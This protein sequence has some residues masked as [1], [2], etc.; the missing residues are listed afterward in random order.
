MEILTIAQGSTPPPFLPQSC[1]VR[2]DRHRRLDV[3]GGSQV[4]PGWNL[5]PILVCCSFL[6]CDSPNL[7]ASKARSGESSLDASVFHGPPQKNQPLALPTDIWTIS[8]FCPTC[9]SRTKLAQQPPDWPIFSATLFPQAFSLPVP[10][11]GT[12]L[13]KHSVTSPVSTADP[14]SAPLLRPTVKSL[15]RHLNPTS[16]SLHPRTSRCTATSPWSDFTP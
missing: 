12:H 2:P 13:D 3:T 1:C 10:G 8:P 7:Q 15:Q 11:N 14:S 6:D 5:P 9:S 16:R 4:R